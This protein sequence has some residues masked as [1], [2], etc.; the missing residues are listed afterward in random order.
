MVLA[1]FIL[2]GWLIILVVMQGILLIIHRLGAPIGLVTALIVLVIS[3]VIQEILLIICGVRALIVLVMVLIVLVISVVIWGILL[4]VH[5]FIDEIHT[6]A[7][8][9]T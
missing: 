6:F 4:I 1:F 2:G 5:I 3:I 8:S 7:A 9:E